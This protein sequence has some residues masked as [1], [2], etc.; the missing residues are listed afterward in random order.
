MKSKL[1]RLGDYITLVDER[2]RDL[3]DTF[4]RGIA[5]SK[6]LIESNANMSGVSLSNYKIVR[7]RQFVYTSDTSRRGDKIALAFNTG[8]VCIVSSIYTVFQVD[9]KRLGPLHRLGEEPAGLREE[10]G[11]PAID[12]RF[13]P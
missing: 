12:L 10:L 9:E 4:L 1:K 7:P 6:Q 2:N 11:G 8:D 5:T 3:A 13:V